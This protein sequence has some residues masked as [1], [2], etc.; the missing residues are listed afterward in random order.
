[1]RIDTPAA[2][3]S[4]AWIV[5]SLRRLRGFPCSDARTFPP[6]PVAE[7]AIV[8]VSLSPRAGVSAADASPTPHTDVGHETADSHAD[9]LA[10]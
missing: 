4:T 5:F 9:R 6:C 2:P 3:E 1:M 7:V 10:S 8:R